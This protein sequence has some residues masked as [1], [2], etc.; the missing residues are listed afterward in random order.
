MRISINDSLTIQVKFVCP[1][2]LLVLMVRL[3]YLMVG[4]QLLTQNMN[5]LFSFRASRPLSPAQPLS[6]NGNGTIFDMDTEKKEVK[7]HK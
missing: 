5:C 4:L 3:D 6:P 2:C 1:F 7:I